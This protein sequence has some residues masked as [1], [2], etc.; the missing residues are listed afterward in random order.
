MK[1]YERIF[2]GIPRVHTFPLLP[3][4]SSPGVGVNEPTPRPKRKKLLRQIYDLQAY[5]SHLQER[6]QGHD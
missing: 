2:E 6:P 4:R 1:I 3:V 5:T